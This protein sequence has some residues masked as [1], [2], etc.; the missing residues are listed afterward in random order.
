MYHSQLVPPGWSLERRGSDAGLR[1]TGDWI[2]LETGVRHVAV[3]R[4]ILKEAVGAESLQI[5]SRDLGHWDSALIAFLLGLRQE[6]ADAKQPF[7]LDESGIPEAARRLLA[8]ATEGTGSQAQA[9]A[10]APATLFAR[11]GT[12]AISGWHQTGRHCRSSP[13]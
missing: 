9:P 4:G 1:L 11:V 12:L 7:R 8:L 5:D 6:I 10:A 2:A 13:A 3:I